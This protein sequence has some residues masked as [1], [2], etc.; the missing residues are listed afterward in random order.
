MKKVLIFAL[1]VM[2]AGTAFGMSDYIVPS[3]WN[4]KITVEVETPEGI[5][6]G[7]AVRQVAAMMQPRFPN[8]DMPPVVYAMRGEAVVVDLGERGRLFALIGSD[9]YEEVDNAFPFPGSD[10][11]SAEGIKYYRSLNPGT[12][13]LLDPTKYPGYPKLVTFTDINDPKTVKLVIKKEWIDE[14]HPI[15]YRMVEDRFEEYFGKGVRLK[16]I[17]IEIADEPVTWEIGKTLSW[18]EKLKN[19]KE[20]LSGSTSIAIMTNDLSDNLGSGSFQLK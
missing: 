1:V 16:D 13:A 19:N 20:R 11:H 6:T 12:K 17:T 4:Y 3:T 8:P 15:R 5:K 2:V 9:S 14:K 10:V 7:S 18:I